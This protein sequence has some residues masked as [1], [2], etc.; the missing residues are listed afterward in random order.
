M[1]ARRASR[2]SLAHMN[3]GHA[4]PLSALELMMLLANQATKKGRVNQ[5]GL[6]PL[7]V[8][9]TAGDLTG[10]NAAVRPA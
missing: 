6:M 8:E 5:L 3:R 2:P 4:P 10:A 9:T 7:I 1:A